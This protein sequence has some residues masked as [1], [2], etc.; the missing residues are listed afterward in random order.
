[1]WTIMT[2]EQCDHVDHCDYVNHYDRW[3]IWLWGPLWQ[4]NFVTTNMWTFLTIWTCVTMWTI[5]TDELCDY[6]DLSDCDFCDYHA[7][8]IKHVFQVRPST[9]YYLNWSDK[10]CK[11]LDAPIYEDHRTKLTPSKFPHPLPHPDRKQYR[12]STVLRHCPWCWWYYNAAMQT[13]RHWYR[14]L[15]CKGWG[16]WRTWPLLNFYKRKTTLTRHSVHQV[17]HKHKL[18]QLGTVC[19]I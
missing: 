3:T 1:M 15:T 9:I 11:A 5:V 7:L 12:V 16:G 10:F 8:C 2:D 6:M 17:Q 13:L 14:P 18:H 19:L 4:V